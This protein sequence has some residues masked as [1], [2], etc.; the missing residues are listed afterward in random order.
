M[1]ILISGFISGL[2]A[3]LIFDTKKTGHSLNVFVGI[4]G[5]FLGYRMIK[6]LN[7][8]FIQGLSGLIISSF[9]GALILLFIMQM[10]RK[11]F[12]KQTPDQA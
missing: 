11:F 3:G 7:L 12:G 8:S 10:L 4:A 6:E 9:A 2:L 1:Y 5:A